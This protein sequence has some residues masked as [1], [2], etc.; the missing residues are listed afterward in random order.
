VAI[1]RARERLF[2]S[3]A[4][5]RWIFGQQ[6]ENTPSEF[7]RH[8]PAHLISKQGQALSPSSARLTPS[9]PG[10]RGGHRAI[11][12]SPDQ[13]WVDRSFDQSSPGPSS[14]EEG[15]SFW[16]GMQVQHSKFGVGEVQVITGS[17]PNLNLTI[18]FS[19]VGP[20]TVRSQFVQPA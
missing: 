7:L 5:R 20:K 14:A 16:V 9:A 13:V 19:A 8:I 18:Y 12:R 4:R 15:C 1:T 2:L 10:S 17:V 3:H 6:Q 11:R